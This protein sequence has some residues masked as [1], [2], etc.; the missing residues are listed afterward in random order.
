M[1]AIM[2]EGPPFALAC[3][4]REVW[5]TR[6]KILRRVTAGGRLMA[7]RPSLFTPDIVHGLRSFDGRTLR[8]LCGCKL[9]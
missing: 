1:C 3:F 2:A 9:W 7:P 5:D 4:L 6:L 8:T